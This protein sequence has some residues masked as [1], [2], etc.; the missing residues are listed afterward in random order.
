M[1][2]GSSD[3]PHLQNRRCGGVSSRPDTPP[4]AIHTA[5]RL[6]PGAV[7]RPW[8]RSSQRPLGQGSVRSSCSSPSG[9][10]EVSRQRATERG[11]RWRRCTASCGCRAAA[12]SNRVP[13]PSAPRMRRAQRV[14]PP[15]QARAGWRLPVVQHRALKATGVA[16]I[17]GGMEG[18][19]PS[20]SVVRAGGTRWPRPPPVT[21][22]LPGEGTAALSQ[23]ATPCGINP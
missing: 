13:P 10:E 9:A 5:T 4:S 1:F 16:P 11:E 6:L 12:F 19:E 15:R 2:M 18:G 8:L 17:S 3:P 7:L 21:A 23:F 22:L 14:A 20:R